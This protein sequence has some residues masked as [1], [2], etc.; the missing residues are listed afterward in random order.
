MNKDKHILFYKSLLFRVGLIVFAALSFAIVVGAID[1]Y[2]IVMREEQKSALETGERATI[3]LKSIGSDDVLAWMFEYWEANSERM[4]FPS[5]K[6]LKDPDVAK[7]WANTHESVRD[8]FMYKEITSEDLESLSDDEQLLVAEY[9]YYVMNGGFKTVVNATRDEEDLRCAVFKYIGDDQAYVF[10]SNS[11]SGEKNAALGEVYHFNLSKHPVVSKVIETGSIPDKAERITDPETGREYLY[12][13]WPMILNGEVSAIVGVQYPWSETEDGLLDR[14]FQIGGR[15]FLYMIF[16]D[17]LLLV[18]LNLL[19]LAP[20]KRLQK[21][22]RSFATKKDSTEVEQELAAINR[23][24]D[25]VGSLS[26]DVT[27]LAKEVDRYIKEVYTLAGEK[28]AAQAELSVATKIQADVLP[29][30]FTAFS[31]RKEFELYA[32]MEPALE[33]GGDFYDFFMIDEDH[34]ALVIA[35]VSD[36]GI[37]SAMF[38]MLTQIMIE[39]MAQSGSGFRHP[40]DLFAVMNNRLREKNKV[41]MFVTAWM[42]VVEISTG[43]AACANAGHEYPAIFRPA[44]SGNEDSGFA[45][46]KVPHSPP[47]GAY[48]GV[49]FCDEDLE[50]HPGDVIFV[51]T[52]GVT[53]ASDSSGGMFGEE[54]LLLAL[55]ELKNESPEGIIKGVRDRIARFKGENEQFD[56]ITMLCFKYLGTDK[57]QK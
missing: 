43:K 22:I 40:K 26:T 55:N 52:D 44:V 15:V 28:A 16:A 34:L 24:E 56:D 39:T 20:V 23:R 21:E 37:P 10:F 6:D 17:I 41:E 3:L 51:Y 29:K 42:G 50:L 31:N 46:H 47:L 49:P 9:E 54:R 13:A 1:T 12:A 7:E 35:D 53:D 30:D 5:D 45:F 32:F 2:Y 11:V 8:L 25:E 38:M 14:I 48:P 18:V 33:V 4:T 27:D 57:M 36:K 19:I